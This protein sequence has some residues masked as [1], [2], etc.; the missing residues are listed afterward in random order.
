MNRGRGSHGS[1]GWLST[2]LVAVVTV[3]LVVPGAAFGKPSA[4]PFEI[5]P[6]SAHF[7]TS[8]GQ[9]GAHADVT[10]SF[11]FAH[12]GTT[13]PTFNDARNVAVQYPAGFIGDVNAIPTCTFAQLVGNV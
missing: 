2:L 12:E 10:V 4:H 6:G 7:T 5:V 3:C 8:T 1:A 9:A 13:G 11:D